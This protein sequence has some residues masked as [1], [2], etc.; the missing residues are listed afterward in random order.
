MTLRATVHGLLAR[1]GYR[2]E[3]ITGEAANGERLPEEFE[4]FYAACRSYTMTSRERMYALYEGVRYVS[5]RGVPGAIVECGVWRGGSVMLAAHTLLA[6]DDQ[7]D[8]WLY[9]TFEGMPEPTAGDVAADGAGVAE[10]WRTSG[11]DWC[12]SSLDE[13]RRNVESTGIAP[14]R[15]H[16]V[17][18][19]VEDT[20]PEQAPGPIALLR[21]DTDW[22]DS[23][24]HELEHLYPLLAPGGVLIVDDYGRWQGQRLA[25]DEYCKEHGITLLLNR[26]D[27]P[28]RIAV[29][30]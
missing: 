14:G 1:S 10:Q 3:R 22:Y 11:G 29:K 23:S 24:R 4:R 30:A 19:K 26:I 7:R 12:R 25:V 16:F 15:L 6:L 2:V 5:H 20:L 17:Q 21:L 18:G 8:I 27:G 9:D 28:G 13:C